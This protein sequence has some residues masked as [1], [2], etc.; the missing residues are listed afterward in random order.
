MLV[1]KL[2][3]VKGCRSNT[4]AVVCVQSNNGQSNDECMGLNASHTIH[5]LSNLSALDVTCHVQIY[6]TSGTHYLTTHLI[7]GGRGEF[8]TLQGHLSYPPSVIQC[9]AEDVGI[10]FIKTNRFFQP[11][12][13]VTISNLVVQNCGREDVRQFSS[14]TAA[15]HF[16][17]MHSYTLENVTIANSSDHGLHATDCQHNDIRKVKFLFSSIHAL[18]KWTIAYRNN[19]A[20][21][22][23]YNTQ[24]MNSTHQALQIYSTEAPI[25][26]H[27]TGCNFTNSAK[28]IQLYSNELV[29]NIN[30]SQ[31]CNTG[32]GV[33]ISHEPANV[34]AEPVTIVISNCVFSHGSQALSI[35]VHPS[36]SILSH[37]INISSCL[38]LEND[39]VNNS[40][41]V[42]IGTKTEY[43]WMHMPWPTSKTL[44]SRIM[45]DLH[46]A[47]I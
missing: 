16:T 15:L 19:E 23:I 10:Q 40:S 27:I 21:V 29:F 34:F 36:Q 39:L 12:R 2:G 47:L 35:F 33:V 1:L 26:I 5:Q 37:I 46:C 4:S 41:L 43:G 7:F 14:F 24:F 11:S 8:I 3:T 18:M 25:D 44:S 30:S 45:V 31:F 9:N 32:L 20:F 6:F 22:N 42:T 13:V 38:F 28:A 17:N